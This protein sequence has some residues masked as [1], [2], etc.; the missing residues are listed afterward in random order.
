M[1]DVSRSHPGQGASGGSAGA[2]Q[3]V[4]QRALP[5]AEA[6]WKEFQDDNGM[7]LAAALSFYVFL[8]IF[9]LIL[10]AIGIVGL[11]LGSPQNAERLIVGTAA[12]YAASPEARS[13]LTQVVHGSRAAT[14]IGLL[15]LLW[16]G[17]SVVT[18]LEDALNTAWDV[19]R[20]PGFVR[21]RAWALLFLLVLGGLLVVSIAVTSLVSWVVSGASTI[22]PHWSWVSTLFSYLVPVLISVA[23][24]TLAYKL[25]PGTQVAW[26]QAL[27]GG[28]FSGILWEIAKQAFTFYAAHFAD[29][30]KVYGSIGSVILFLVWIYYSAIITIL[31][32]ELASYSAR[33]QQAREE[34][35]VA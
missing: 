17:T 14:G 35:Q 8:S 2:W 26:R 19:R 34:R 25:L 6:V 4:R 16:S 31:G 1:A 10:A 18:A 28:V 13:L 32:A 3:W 7:V 15:L 27:V 5:Y 20:Q 29:Y 11:V 23:A 33:Q 21:R 30:N 12:P 9:P 24:F 22:L